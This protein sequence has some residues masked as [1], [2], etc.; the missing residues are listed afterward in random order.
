MVYY[1]WQCYAEADAPSGSCRRC[2]GRVEA[3]AQATYVERLLWAL[4]HPLA[5]RQMI[6]A[7]VLGRRRERAA[8]EPLRAIALTAPDPYL[9]AQA[10]E[11]LIEIEGRETLREML[12]ELSSSAP[13]QVRKVAR[14][15][16]QGGGR[17]GRGDY[18]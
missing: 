15:H 8:V 10:L 5:E 6:A 2:G 1:C 4:D 17:G 13:A 7:K 9:A 11:S 12:L 3:P 16:S 18:R 14:A